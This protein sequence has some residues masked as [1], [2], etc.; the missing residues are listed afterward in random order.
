MFSFVETVRE[1]FIVYL[2]W[3]FLRTEFLV[4][5]V[6]LN[7]SLL[8][9]VSSIFF[10]LFTYTRESTLQASQT[11]D[12]LQGCCFGLHKIVQ[13]HLINRQLSVGTCGI[14]QYIRIVNHR[15]TA[16]FFSITN[17]HNK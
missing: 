16:A 6:I 9:C 4:V 17:N 3:S 13:L 11:C 12:L 2:T 8:I 7:C 5:C 1:V 15:S 14:W 10:I